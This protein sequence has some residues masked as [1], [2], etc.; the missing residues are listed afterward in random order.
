MGF[1]LQTCE[2]YRQPHLALQMKKKIT[3]ETILKWH[4]VKCFIR[5]CYEKWHSCKCEPSPKDGLD[6]L[7]PKR[8]LKH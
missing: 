3:N 6:L 5:Q 1:Q 4:K 2:W 8:T 7:M